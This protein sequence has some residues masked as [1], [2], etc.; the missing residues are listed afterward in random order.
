[1]ANKCNRVCRADLR[2]RSSSPSSGAEPD[3]EIQH[4]LQSRLA[5]VYGPIATLPVIAN[6]QVGGKTTLEPES[7]A[8]G[9]DDGFEFRLFATSKG[10]KCPSDLKTGRIIL[11]E[12]D[13]SVVGNGGFI[14]PWRDPRYYFT[15]EVTELQKQQYGTAAVSGED[16][17]RGLQIRH[18]G[19]EVPWRVSTIKVGISSY[20]KLAVQDIG[21]KDE[22]K[23][24]VDGQSKRKRIGK[25][26]RILHRKREKIHKELQLF[27][28]EKLAV[29]ESAEREKKTKRNRE[30]QQKKRAKEKAKKAG[31]TSEAGSSFAPAQGDT[32]MGEG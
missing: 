15:G 31:N 26:M 22:E 23:A 12:D 2:S 20:K 1:M 13:E 18:A 32:D 30:K 25:K 7:Q 14:I 5:E 6:T 28:Q 21:V 3:E 17:L 10:S 4:L 24:P 8:D 27:E 19:L 16:V 29:R 11:E 9:G